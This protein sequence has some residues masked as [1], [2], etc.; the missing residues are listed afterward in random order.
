MDVK[1]YWGKKLL[2]RCKSTYPKKKFGQFQQPNLNPEFLT[3]FK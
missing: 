3:L 2:K 1:K